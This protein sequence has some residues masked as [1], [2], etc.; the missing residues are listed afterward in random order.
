MKFAILVSQFNPEINEGLFQG[1]IQFLKEKDISEK[2]IHRFEVPGA[3]E[4]PLVAQKLARSGKY[5]GVICLGCVIKG[6][7]AH[8]EFISAGTSYGLM[9]AM[10][11][12]QVPIAF[13][14]LTT[15]SRQQAQ[16]R[17]QDNPENKGREAAAACWQTAELLHQID[18]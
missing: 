13:G 14:V 8:F 4:L 11:K 12:T 5:S 10:L 16:E 3:F 15:Y 7:T 2:K 6:E 9:Q 1:A 18:S 17:S